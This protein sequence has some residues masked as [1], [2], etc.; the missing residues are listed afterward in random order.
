[1][2]KKININNNNNN[3]RQ[4][5]QQ[6][7]RKGTRANNIMVLECFFKSRPE[8]RGFR[9]RMF[10]LWREQNPESQ[11]S[12]QGLLNQ[13][14]A[15]FT[16][17]LASDLEIQMMRAK[18]TELR[19]QIENDDTRESPPQTDMVN[20]VMTES[21]SSEIQ[22]YPLN[23]TEDQA[24]QR[25][26]IVNYMEQYRFCLLYTSPSPRDLSTSRMPSSA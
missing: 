11:I 4:H 20:D 24:R 3:K 10:A 8:K 14:R 2:I 7:R 6:E 12:E 21:H 25:N 9:K 26:Q 16:N 5:Q 15:I 22:Q 19:D 23:L 13:K 1:M 17:K 18:C